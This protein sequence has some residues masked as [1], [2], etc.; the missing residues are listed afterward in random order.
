MSVDTILAETTPRAMRLALMAG[1]RLVELHIDRPGRGHR[2]GDVFV[3]RVSRVVAALDAC[4]VDLGEGVAGFLKAGEADTGD[5]GGAISK[6]VQEGQKLAV[7]IKAEARDEKGPVLTRRFDDRDGRLAA[8]AMRATPPRLISRARMLLARLADDYP[9]ARVIADSPAELAA[10][11]RRARS[12]EAV[13]HQG[14]ALF[15]T[16]GVEEQIERALAPRVTLP[17]GA[18]L[19]FEPVRTLTAVDVDSA[20]ASEAA[21]DPTAINLEA[22]PVLAAQLRLRNLG[23]L[24]VVDFLN[25][26]S[27]EAGRRLVARL[28]DS[29]RDDPAEVVVDGPS[30]FGVVEIARQRRGPTLAE[31]HGP[32]ALASAERLVRRL[33]REAT[34][35]GGAALVIRAAPEVAAAFQGEDGGRAVANWLGRRLELIAERGRGLDDVDIAPEV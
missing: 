22:A 24:I 28:R 13:L 21:H 30:R 17:S 26:G 12:G 32:P 29:F 25:S 14:G 15:E 1:E 11:R 34:A 9:D 35:H 31:Q 16:A 7:A 4:F 33:R 20:R 23:G 18:A 10:L 8:A 3:G 2:Q 19:L 27:E 6:L 5:G